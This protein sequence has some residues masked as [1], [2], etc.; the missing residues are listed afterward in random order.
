MKLIIIGIFLLMELFG[1]FLEYLNFKNRN[2]PLPENVKDVFDAETYA[3]KRAYEM[4]NL[5]LNIISGICGLGVMLAVLAYNLHNFFFELLNI[6]SMYLRVYFMFVMVALISLPLSILFGAIKTFKIEARYGFNKSTV[7]TFIGDIA[8]SQLIMGVLVLGLISLFMLLHGALGNWVFLIFFFVLVAV[9]LFIVFFAHFFS[10]IFNKFTPIEEGSLKEKIDALAAK[11]KFPVKRVYSMDASRRSTKLNAY[12]TGFGRNRTIV[13]YDTLIETMNEDEVI[14][15]LAHEIGH[16]KKR[17]VLV[18]MP[19]AF[20]IM[21]L[22]LLGAFFVVNQVPIST[23]FGFGELNIAFN[24]FV[25]MIFASPV[26]M[27]LQIPRCWISRKFEYAADAYEVSHT[28]K[29]TA[30]SALKKLY[31]EDYGNLTPHPLVV[32]IRHSHPTLTQRI[33]AIEAVEG[34]PD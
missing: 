5:R 32:L 20:G 11:T 4:E 25:L 17:H 1:F 29:T 13:L 23:A 12:F 8:K 19:M 2:A 24:I 21:A 34:A 18:S 22:L 14:S 26:M 6:E 3:K 10:R 31:R 16:A 33:S 28:S 7:G 9:M 27:L 15:V 30:I